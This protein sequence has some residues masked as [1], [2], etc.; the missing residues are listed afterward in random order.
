MSK[1][2][3]KMGDDA[4]VRGFFRVQVT[5]DGEVKGDS[6]WKENQVTNLGINQ[7]IVNWVLG[8]TGNGKSVTHMALGT[9]T[10]PGAGDTSLAGEI[11]TQREAVSTSVEASK[12]AQFTA[13]WASS[14]SFLAATAALR[15]VGLFNTSSTGAGT[16][17]AG[18]TYAVSTVNTNQNVQVTYQLRFS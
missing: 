11:D 17:L 5:E 3:K 7:Y 14:D 15:N 2:A 6:G 18:N 4:G 13:A 9:G 8:D 1:K 10:A 12:T 16:M